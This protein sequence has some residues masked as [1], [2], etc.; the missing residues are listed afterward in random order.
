MLIKNN[1]KLKP[2]QT[3][4]LFVPINRGLPTKIPDGKLKEFRK[5]ESCETLF[6]S[7]ISLQVFEKLHK[8]SNE[9][10]R[11]SMGDS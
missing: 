11:F 10:S 8:I 3:Q 2:Y 7:A 1:F 4:D 9:N 6:M 5:K